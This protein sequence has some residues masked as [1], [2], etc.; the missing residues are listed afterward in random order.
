MACETW[1]GKVAWRGSWLPDWEAPWRAL[2]G[3]RR[4]LL[5]VPHRHVV[6]TVPKASPDR[7]R[8]PI[9]PFG[10]VDAHSQRTHAGGIACGGPACGGP[11]RVAS[12]R[13]ARCTSATLAWHLPPS[14][15]N[16]ESARPPARVHSSVDADAIERHPVHVG[17]DPRCVGV[18]CP[19][20]A[21]G[22]RE[23][24]RR[25]APGDTRDARV[26]P[27]GKLDG[28]SGP[29]ASRLRTS[30]GTIWRPDRCHVRHCSRGWSGPTHPRS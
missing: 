10:T 8:R 16:T 6:F 24:E 5:P 4:L 9:P 15:T 11:I 13:G 3:S 25:A 17:F 20:C 14:R 23:G 26:E 1:P 28:Q 22:P 19:G 7:C 12:R 21:L 30:V 2:S 18:G 27:C 29:S